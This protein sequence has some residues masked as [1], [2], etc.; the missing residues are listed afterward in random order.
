MKPFSQRESFKPVRSV[1]QVDSMDDALRNGLWNCL[2]V[3]YWREFKSDWRSTV[4]KWGFLSLTYRPDVLLTLIWD[5]YFKERLDTL[6]RGFTDIYRVIRERFFEAQWYEVYD[7]TE[8]VVQN[9]SD[10]S[11]AMRLMSCCN[12]ELERD[13]SA[14]RFI[15]AIVTP[16]TSEVEIS[17]IEE[18]LAQSQPLIGVKTH[19][20]SALDKLADRESPD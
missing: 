2:E 19:L 15:G 12:S 3:H 20:K 7:F 4:R 10:E 9:D 17:E 6:E 14:Y 11:R 18:A 13:L 16:M 1:M 5:G 8:F